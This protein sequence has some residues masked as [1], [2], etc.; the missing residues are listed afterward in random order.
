[1]QNEKIIKKELSKLLYTLGEE[2]FRT[3]KI[4]E[5]NNSNIL[6]IELVDSTDWF[7]LMELKA[8][9]F[10]NMKEYEKLDGEA[11]SEL[12]V[13]YVPMPEFTSTND[14]SDEFYE[15]NEDFDIEIIWILNWRD[16]WVKNYSELNIK[17]TELFDEIL[18]SKIEYIISELEI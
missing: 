17:E 18:D 6:K 11:K 13:L 9:I 1:M 16:L 7:W 3:P 8:D 2:W 14:I 4:I 15:Y 5:L 10:N 12:D